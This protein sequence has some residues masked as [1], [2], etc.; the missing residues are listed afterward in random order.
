[1]LT[2]S[3]RVPCWICGRSAEAYRLDDRDGS[4]IHCDLCGKYWISGSLYASG[5]T[6]VETW[7]L[8]SAVRMRSDMGAD[9]TLHSN[10]YKDLI[11][12]TRF[13]DN[14]YELIDLL[15]A[16]IHRRD[17]GIGSQV[18]Y[19]ASVDY[20]AI[21]VKNQAQFQAIANY[22]GELG[23]VR[24]PDNMLAEIT[25]QGWERMDQLTRQ[26]AESNKAFVAMWFDRSMDEAWLNGI[27]PA[28]EGCG[29]DPVRMDFK[30][31]NNDICD[32]IISEIRNA[33][34]TI[35]DLT[36]NRGGVYYE[37]GF[38]YGI[39]R[40]VILCCNKDWFDENGVHFDLNHYNIIVW[41]DAPDLLLKLN[42]R[43]KATIT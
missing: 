32:E 2:E 17:P 5:H 38:A 11:G 40:Q 6:D 16:F 19:D 3:D 18:P 23:Y 42:A 7:K 41:D 10:A 33:K 8:S 14:P 20:P 43:I 39:G 15:L 26:G 35:A 37:A 24:F 22:A 30:E 12:Q 4:Y 13:P 29:Y 34:F 1:M 9:I 36:G 25:L 27:S 21:A 31:H 28:I